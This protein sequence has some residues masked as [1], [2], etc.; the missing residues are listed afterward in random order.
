MEPLCQVPTQQSIS[1]SHSI[2]LNFYGILVIKKNVLLNVH[3]CRANYLQP[4]LSEKSE[5][6]E[7]IEELFLYCNLQPGGD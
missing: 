2:S 7:L 3:Q 5:E 1:V 4:D 6:F